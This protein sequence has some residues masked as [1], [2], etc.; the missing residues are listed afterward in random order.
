MT[1]SAEKFWYGWLKITALLTI[2]TG[3]KLSLFNTLPTFDFLSKPINR[4]FNF[5]PELARIIAPLQ[6]WLVSVLGATMAGWGIT[7]LFLISYP[8]QKK[9]AWSWN[10]IMLSLIVWY[11]IDTFLS[12]RAGVNFNVVINTI[13][14]IQFIAPLLFLRNTMIKEQ[15]N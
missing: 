3:L 1:S 5:N 7:V 14:L 8:L 12:A 2:L 6:N 4:I 15:Q 11:T 10:A 13:F 9:E